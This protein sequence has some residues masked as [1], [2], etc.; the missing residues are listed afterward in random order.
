MAF[1]QL[2][3]GL[4]QAGAGHQKIP[5]K[6]KPINQSLTHGNTSNHPNNSTTSQQQYVT[7]AGVP[8]SNLTY[9]SN[10]S[11]SQHES[12]NQLGAPK[13]QAI[14]SP[15]RGTAASSGLNHRQGGNTMLF[16]QGG[17]AAS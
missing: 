11:R 4:S 3:F 17:A 14:Y 13:K 7:S 6:K 8:H 10:G 1:S 2:D 15:D 9:A 16:H 5:S 12:L